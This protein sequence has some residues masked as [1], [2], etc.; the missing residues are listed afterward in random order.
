MDDLGAKL[1]VTVTRR[2][3]RMSEEN[4]LYHTHTHTPL[5]KP[6]SFGP[7]YRRLAKLLPCRKKCGQKRR[8]SQTFLAST[9]HDAKILWQG[10]TASYGA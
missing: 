4:N 9:T 6:G 1:R 3:Q 2:S 8:T 5:L 10:Q 7:W